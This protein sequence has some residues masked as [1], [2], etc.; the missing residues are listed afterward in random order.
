MQENGR[1]WTTTPQVEIGHKTIGM[2]C[3]T[4]GGR[5]PQPQFSLPHRKTAQV[6]RLPT[7]SH[8]HHQEWTHPTPQRITS[9]LTAQTHPRA[10]S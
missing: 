6:N 2:H 10:R 4:K 8:A 5:E 7:G 1:M 9:P 3:P